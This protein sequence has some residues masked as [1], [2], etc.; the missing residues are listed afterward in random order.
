MKYG[1]SFAR[2]RPALWPDTAQLCDELG[3]ESVWLPEHLVLPVQSTGSPYA[4]Q[5]HPPVPAGVPVFDVFT[6]LAFIAARTE[7]LRLGTNVY[8]IGLRHPFVTARAVATLDVI[9]GGRVE[10]GIGASWLAEEWAAAGLDFATRGR[11]VDE[12]LVVCRRLW[13]EPVVEHHGDFFDFGPVMFE[14]KP[15]QRPGPPITVGGDSAPAR[16]RVALHGDGWIPMNTSLEKLPAAC[17]D[18]A[19][20][21]A[22]AGRDARFEL[23]VM[24]SLTGD[25]AVADYEAAGVDRLIVSPWRRS[26][27]AADGLREFA[28]AHL[29][30]SR[31]AAS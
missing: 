27:E 26:A 12:A 28:A 8:N 10:L 30:G 17:D 2:L 7:R 24:G 25:A 16:R 14:P 5:D 23:T 31:P 13:A 6:M 3:F 1:V 22:D 9:S 29:A 18:I 15:V 4:G 11:R 20:M 21:R 19:R